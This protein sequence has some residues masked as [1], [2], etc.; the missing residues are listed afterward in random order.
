MFQKEPPVGMCKFN[1]ADGFDTV[2]QYWADLILRVQ[3]LL[4]EI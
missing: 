3:P 1:E 2:N 4:F